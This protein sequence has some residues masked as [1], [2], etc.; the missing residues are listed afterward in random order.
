MR[1]ACFVM[2]EMVQVFSFSNAS[3]TLEVE[4]EE[5]AG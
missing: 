4:Q 2:R 1:A 5:T 3:F